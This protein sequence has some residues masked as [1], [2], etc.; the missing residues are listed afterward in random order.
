M[1]MLTK[2]DRIGQSI[3]DEDSSGFHGFRGTVDKH[4]MSLQERRREA[5][6][7]RGHMSLDFLPHIHSLLAQDP[8]ILYSGSCPITHEWVCRF[9]LPALL[10]QPPSCSVLWEHQADSPDPYKR[11]GV[12][13]RYLRC[14]RERQGP[15]GGSCLQ[16]TQMLRMCI[17]CPF[18][19]A[20]ASAGLCSSL[21]S[22][23]RMRLTVPEAHGRAATCLPSSSAPQETDK[24]LLL[25]W[26]WFFNLGLKLHQQSFNFILRNELKNILS[27]KT[28]QV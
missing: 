10:T 23:P 24:I 21:A 28:N 18:S 15:P 16:D 4:M 9:P 3:V 12:G 26:S 14:T 17:P 11:H 1:P 6:G 22:T 8:E 19:D 13:S 20:S 27:T 5:S 7:S 2:L 25:P